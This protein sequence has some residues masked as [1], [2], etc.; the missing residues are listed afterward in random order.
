MTIPTGPIEHEP[1]NVFPWPDTHTPCAMETTLRDALQATL[2]GIELGAHDDRIIRWLT[3]WEPSTV[4]TICSW[5]IR[6]RSQGQQ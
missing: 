5:I 2:D 6:A 1:A 3:G 4:A